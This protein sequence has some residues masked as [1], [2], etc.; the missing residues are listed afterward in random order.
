SGERG[1]SGTG[2]R[3]AGSGSH[4]PGRKGWPGPGDAAAFRDIEH[5][6]R[7]FASDFG[8]VAWDSGALGADVI[9]SLK[10]ILEDTLERI[11]AEVF[12]QPAETADSGKAADSAET[13]DDA[14]AA[15][16]DEQSPA[17][18]PESGASSTPL[19][20]DEPSDS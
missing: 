5:L 10:G 6:A 11:K 13:A 8:K 12:T 3:G 16:P 14:T 4:G 19:I 18:S 2:E 1:G 15:P 7:E 9:G 17:T 20:P